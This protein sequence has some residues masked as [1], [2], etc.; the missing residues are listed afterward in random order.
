MYLNKLRTPADNNR[1]IYER[2]RQAIERIESVYDPDFVFTGQ[3]IKQKQYLGSIP[4]N[5]LADIGRWERGWLDLIKNVNI[6][7]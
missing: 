3:W 1:A 4:L 7:K 5:T 6:T 2:M